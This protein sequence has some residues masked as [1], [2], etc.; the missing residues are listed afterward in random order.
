MEAIIEQ[1]GGPV[2]LRSFDV[3]HKDGIIFFI[4]GDYKEQIEKQ[5]IHGT[6]GKVLISKTQLIQF[7]HLYLLGKIK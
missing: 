4:G 3:D 5:Q 7:T 1:M 2:T 6:N